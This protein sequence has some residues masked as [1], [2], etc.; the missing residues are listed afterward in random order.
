VR[1]T[2]IDAATDP[3][4]TLSYYFDQNYINLLARSTYWLNPYSYEWGFYFRRMKLN[5]KWANPTHLKLWTVKAVYRQYTIVD[6]SWNLY[7]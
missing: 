3:T 4:F 1:G 7:L 5:G 6:K 2:I